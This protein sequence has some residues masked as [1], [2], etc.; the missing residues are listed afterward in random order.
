MAGDEE[1]GGTVNLLRDGVPEARRGPAFIG[2]SH[3]QQGEDIT[4]H[5]NP[6]EEL[7]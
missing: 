2:I 7:L 5:L 1:R 4:G 6:G 3:F